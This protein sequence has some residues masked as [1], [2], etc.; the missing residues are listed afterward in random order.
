MHLTLS[1]LSEMLLCASIRVIENKKKINAINI[2]PVPDSDTGSN[3]AKMFSAIKKVIETETFTNINS[4]SDAVLDAVLSS[5]QGNSGMMMASYL[6]GF[7]KPFVNKKTFDPDD[8]AKAAK[9]GAEKAKQSVEMPIEGTMLD[10]MNAFA[11][12]VATNANPFEETLLDAIEQT[13]IALIR[14][15]NHMKLLKSHHVVDA[16]ALGFTHFVYGLYEGVNKTG[17][18]LTGIDIRPLQQNGSIINTVRFPFEVIFTVSE[19]QFSPGEFK[20]I[21]HELGDS[22]DVVR[23]Q[24][25][26]KVHIHTDT[27]DVIK[28]TAQLTGK[29]VKLQITD[30]R[31]TEILHTV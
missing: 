1:D 6:D 22:L 4:F 24:N 2:F 5:S 18:E 17:L 20:N 3:L 27:P 16:G 11:A 13:R 7:L 10:V 29:I 26:V 21:F 25:T 15:E 23:I 8:F 28:E 19:A 31:T 14:T 30:M 9:L 12:A